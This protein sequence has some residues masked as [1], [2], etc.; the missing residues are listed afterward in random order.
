MEPSAPSLHHDTYQCTGE[1]CHEHEAICSEGNNGK[2]GTCETVDKPAATTKIPGKCDS[3]DQ[4]SMKVRSKS[5]STFTGAGH[6]NCCAASSIDSF[7]ECEGQEH[8]CA[9][10]RCI[11]EGAC[12]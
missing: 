9:M 2:G 5:P 7:G 10:A 4:C 11:I 8:S 3:I 6:C 12:D 1:E